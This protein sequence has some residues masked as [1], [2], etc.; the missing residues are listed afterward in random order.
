MFMRELFFPAC[1]YIRSSILPCERY[2]RPHALRYAVTQC[3][4]SIEFRIA[5][6]TLYPESYAVQYTA[7]ACSVAQTLQSDLYV[8]VS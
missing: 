6:N 2:D 4:K 7:G 5:S 8:P 3:R 1:A